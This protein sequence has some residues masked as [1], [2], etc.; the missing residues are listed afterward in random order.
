MASILRTG[1]FG[2]FQAFGFGAQDGSAATWA[3]MTPLV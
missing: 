1:F 2:D 3:T